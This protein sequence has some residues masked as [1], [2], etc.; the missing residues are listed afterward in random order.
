MTTPLDY[1]ILRREQQPKAT[2]GSIASITNHNDEKTTEDG[3]AKDILNHLVSSYLVHHGYAQTARA[4]TKQHKG[5]V[6][7][8]SV[9][10]PSPSKLHAEIGTNKEGVIEDDIET[11]TNIVNSILEGRIDFAIDTLQE[12][13]PNV[14]E[15]DDHLMFFKLRCRK[16]VELM[17][18]T[19]EMKKRLKDIQPKEIEKQDDMDYTQ[20]TWASEDMDMDIDDDGSIP[21]DFP[22]ALDNSTIWR[23]TTSALHMPG[24]GNTMAKYESALNEAIIYGQTL[25]NDYQSDP[26]PEVQQLFK[27]TFG[28]VAWEDPLK[29]GGATADLVGH[30]ARVA[31]SHEVNQ[32]IL[33][34]FW[35]LLPFS[36]VAD[37]PLL[38]RITRATSTTC[39]RDIVSTYS[40]LRYPAWSPGGGL[41]CVC[42]YA[43]R[44]SPVAAMQDLFTSVQCLLQMFISFVFFL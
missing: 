3:E 36:V 16:F 25:A 39:V 24:T 11:R 34:T 17:L 29:A 12:K 7:S 31:L 15:V 30:N 6:S 8:E 37:N 5:R 20:N 21:S 22:P 40:R 23:S 10:S 9:K 33:S 4:F 41:C 13:F 18:E 44:I 35:K 2:I 1:T 32:A 38:T 28:I 42:G 43:T 19:A 14:L 27:K 26:R